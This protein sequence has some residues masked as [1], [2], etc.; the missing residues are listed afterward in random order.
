MTAGTNNTRIWDTVYTEGGSNLWYPSEPLVGLVRN[1]ERREGLDGIV[2]DHGCGSGNTAE[3]LVRSGHRVACGDV[4]PAALELVR[5]RFTGAKLRPAPAFY[6]IDSERPLAGQLPAYDHV[7]AWSSLQY[8]PLAKARADFADLIA[9]LPSG[10]AFFAAVASPD[11]D[12]ATRSQALPDGSRRLIENVS[13]QGGVTVAI[14]RDFDEFESWCAGIEVRE[15][16][17]FGIALTSHRHDC[18]GI[19]GV[20]K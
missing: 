18:Y 5:G 17:R 9:G 3:F 20:K 7:V 15:R 11:D 6:T 8:N 16:A 13:G 1:H 12:L 14:P 2:L 19:Y 4:S 10:G